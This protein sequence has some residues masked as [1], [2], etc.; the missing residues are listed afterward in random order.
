MKLFQHIVILPVTK[1][2][3]MNHYFIRMKLLKFI[4]NAF[5][6]KTFALR[7]IY[8]ITRS[9]VILLYQFDTFSYVVH[10][11]HHPLTILLNG[12][13]LNLILIFKRNNSPKSIAIVRSLAS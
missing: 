11:R 8:L 5:R 10:Y 6:E 3:V 9:D 13:S 2:N 12:I 4:A 7:F 1:T